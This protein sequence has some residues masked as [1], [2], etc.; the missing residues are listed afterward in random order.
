MFPEHG[1]KACDF[2]VISCALCRISHISRRCTSLGHSNT[3]KK[4]WDLGGTHCGGTWGLEPTGDG[5]HERRSNVE[6]AVALAVALRRLCV[7]EAIQGVCGVAAV[8]VAECQPA[9][10]R[11]HEMKCFETLPSVK[12]PPRGV[13]RARLPGS[14]A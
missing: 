5:S 9:S 1:K 10:R 4:L 2:C 7:C 13:S 12:T 14:A 3:H 6:P 8:V 11:G